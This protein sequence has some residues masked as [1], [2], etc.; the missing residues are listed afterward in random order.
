MFWNN[1]N[2]CPGHSTSKNLTLEDNY[3]AAVTHQKVA[4]PAWTGSIT[5]RKRKAELGVKDVMGQ[6]HSHR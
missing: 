2:L 3:L 6:T 1:Y 4:S 5:S